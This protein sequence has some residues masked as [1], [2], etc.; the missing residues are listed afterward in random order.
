MKKRTLLG[1][2]VAFVALSASAGGMAAGTAVARPWQPLCQ[3]LHSAFT[4]Y[5]DLA[6]SAYQQGDMQAYRYYDRLGDRNY[7]TYV[8]RGC[9]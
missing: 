5:Y 1:A 2:A 6:S 4:G 7:N 8:A 9:N 3:D